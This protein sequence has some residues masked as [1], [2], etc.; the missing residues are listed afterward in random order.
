MRARRVFV[1]TAKAGPRMNGINCLGAE[2][3]RWG[4]KRQRNR[5]ADDDR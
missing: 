1:E 3:S 2:R 4:I 5:V